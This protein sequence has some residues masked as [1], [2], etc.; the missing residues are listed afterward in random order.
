M[1]NKMKAMVL[2]APGG[3]EALQARRVDMPWPAAAGDVL[4]RLKVAA[5]NP[6]DAYFRSFGPYLDQGGPCVLGHDAAGIVEQVGKEVTRVRP[7]QRVCFCNGGIGG[8]FGTYAEFAVVP[9]TQLSLVPD[10]V[11]DATAA[12]LPLVFITA[13]ESLKER[14]GVKAG[15]FVLIHAGAGGTGHI[16]VQ[17]AAELGGR[18]AT[19]VSSDEK[20]ALVLELGAERPIAYRREDFVEV[21]REW[22]AEHGLDVALD[23][24]GPQIFQ[25]T[26]A[27][28]A[29]YGRLV[30][31]MGMP[32][33]DAEDTAYVNNLTIHN[34][35]MLT[36]MLLGLQQ[37]LDH[38][39]TIVA[40]GLQLLEQGKLRLQIDSRYDF[41]DIAAA[42]ERLDAGNACGKIIIDIAS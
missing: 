2:D 28:M 3:P 25:K 35:M 16:A 29:P 23:N 42:H 32:A 7:G 26:I 38:Q 13:W 39:A 11:E 21:A 24:L 1:N 34:V 37:R 5:L 27:A 31:L 33:D 14:A 41:D 40:R 4:V 17:V 22:T 8:H 10:A 20:I 9:E 6:A 30:T 18:V 36:P 15:D 19:T 12:A